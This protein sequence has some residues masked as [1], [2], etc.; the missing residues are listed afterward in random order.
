MGFEISTL[1]K[2]G[3]ER[4]RLPFRRSA[5]TPKVS[6]LFT[7]KRVNLIAI[8]TTDTPS[9]GDLLQGPADSISRVRRAFDGYSNG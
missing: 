4:A 7:V 6:A 8:L 9:T 5:K 3:I 1:E 2:I